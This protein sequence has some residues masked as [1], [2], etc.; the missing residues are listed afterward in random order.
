MNIEQIRGQLLEHG[1][2]PAEL[3]RLHRIVR[4][5]RMVFRGNVVYSTVGRR[6]R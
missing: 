5:P 4:D 3:D 6:P 1:F 2:T